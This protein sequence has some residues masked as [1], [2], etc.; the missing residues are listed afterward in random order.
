[1]AGKPEDATA[2]APLADAVAAMLRRELAGS[3]APGLHI[4]A[5]PIGN[6]ADISLR[7]LAVLARADHVL[8]EDTRHSQKLLTAYGLRTR[9]TP[10]HDHNAESQRPK[11]LAW[12]EG[13]AAVALISDAGTPLI[14]D[15]GYKLVRAAT[16]AG[17]KVHAV[18]GPS[19]AIAALSI[20]GLPTDAFHFAG[21]LPPKQAARRRRLDELAEIP[22]TL[23]LYETAPRLNEALNDLGLAMAGR[24]VVVAR[25]LTKRFEEAIRGVLPLSLSD[26][27]VEAKGEIVILVSPPPEHEPAQDEIRE[28]VAAA[29]ERLSL[30]DAV[31]EV[32]RTLRVPRRVVYAL[33]LELQKA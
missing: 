3:L 5:T 8:C 22:A 33:A 2:E 7:A 25:E 6:L 29:L 1:M 10:Y 32:T 17:H 13:G 12:L 24:E 16:E 14:A 11:V 9:L 30:R 4:V 31:D 18:P 28:A 20:G 15:P 19:A 27:S 26:E 21:F 23:V